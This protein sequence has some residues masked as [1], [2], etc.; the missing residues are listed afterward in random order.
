MKSAVP[1]RLR[2]IE[3]KHNRLVKHLRTAFSQGEPTPSGACAIEGLRIVEEAIRSGLRLEAVFF[4]ESASNKAERLLSQLRAQVETLVLPD[5]LFAS[6]VPSDTPQ[7][8][9]ALVRV[10]EHSFESMIARS[11]AGVLIATAGIQDPG[12]PDRSF[13]TLSFVRSCWTL[14]RN[15]EGRKSG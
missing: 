4:S 14:S 13:D 1:N 8:M 2:L 10:K 11:H 9:A 15:C 6:T 12:K 3:G 7:G 5:K